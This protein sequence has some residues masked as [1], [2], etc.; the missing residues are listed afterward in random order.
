ME[1][2]TGGNL[3]E[4]LAADGPI[5]MQQCIAI[6][7]DVAAALDY[8][9][10]R[11]IVHRDVKPMNVLFTAEGTPKLTDFG[12]AKLF[13]SAVQTREGQLLGSPAYMSPEQITGEPIDA[14][15]DIYSLGASL[16]QMLT[17][18]VPFEGDI[19]SILAQHVNKPPLPPSAHDAAIPANLDEIV[20][21]M[22]S[23]AAKDRFQD[24]G[25]LTAALARS[26]GKNGSF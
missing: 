20:L 16:Y 13:A 12:N 7:L 21:R 9:H 19:G 18:N 11:G 6:V 14:R 4:R 17:G 24:C 1:L 26:V 3:A 15:S 23:K 22:L 25:E 2:L 10:G 5:P 8:A